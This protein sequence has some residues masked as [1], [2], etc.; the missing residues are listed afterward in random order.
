M[1]IGGY[2]GLELNQG[3]EFH[4]GAI[5]LNTGR[6]ALEYILRAKGYKKIY[7]P[8]FTCDALFEPIEK[9]HLEIE[10]YPIDETFYP[11]FDFKR[12]KPAEIFLYTNYFGLYDRHVIEITKH[13]KNIL[14]DNAQAFYSKPLPGIDTFYSPRKFFGL[15]DGAYLFTNKI[16]NQNLEQD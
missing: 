2:F 14:I 11:I 8:Y 7:L 5:R 10:F 1:A 3:S 13:T 16:L 4:P 9:L 6:N 15:P 12:V